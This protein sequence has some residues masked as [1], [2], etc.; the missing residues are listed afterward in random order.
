MK[1]TAVILMLIT[2]V[3][4]VTGLLR[5]IVLSYFYG[6]STLSDVYLISITISSVI[7]GFI[8]TGISTGYIPLYRKI[9][10]KYGIEEGN[11]FTSN[12]V[13]ILMLFCTIIVIFGLSYTELLV[14]VFASGFEGETL[15]LAV[16]FTRISLIG[17]YF[18]GLVLV[19]S[20]FLQL[21]DNYTIPALVAFPMNLIIIISIYIASSMDSTV[22]AIG[23][24]V[25]T[26]SQLFLL[27][28]FVY[29]K[30]YSYKLILDFKDEHIK[31]LA[32]ISLPLI[33]G[34]SINQ[35]NILVDRTIASQIAI[36]GVSA[37]NYANRLNLFVQ[38][39]F[40]LSIATAMFP[41]ISKMAVENNMKGFKKTLVESISGINLLVMPATVGFMVLA[42]P[43]VRLLFGRGAFDDQAVLM[44]S[45][46]LFFFSVGMIGF[47][48][49]EVLSRA[50]YSLQDTKT[51]MINAAIAVILNIILNFILSKFLGIGG[52]ALATSISG[53]FCTMLLMINLR[54]KIG[55]YGMKGIIIAFLKIFIAS[56]IMGVIVKITYSI[57]LNYINANL[58][59]IISI[60][61]G[62]GVYF[63]MLLFMK[64][65]EVDSIFNAIKGKIV[66]IS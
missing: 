38:G 6:A 31:N 42:E 51:P 55:P 62:G 28:P 27:I 1:K 13:N 23:T 47:G 40:V 15:A 16:K 50:F 29:K 54:N 32:Y 41:L 18:T 12:L 5:D 7:M 59:L 26:A 65:K 8:I 34:V 45:N 24:V 25:A 66:K 37:L 22:V 52:L 17:V 44:T 43:I 30:G 11:K 53:I 20:S 61:I 36:G 21:H 2:I 35:I 19:F 57:L 39:I 63:A 3:S 58:S 49:R 46:A 14:K 10:K 4:K 48:L 56:I 33:I 64:I 9:E 60:S